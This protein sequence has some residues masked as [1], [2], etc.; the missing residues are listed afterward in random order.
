MKIWSKVGSRILRVF[1]SPNETL[2][3]SPYAINIIKF[4]FAIR[5]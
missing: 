2:Q 5:Y 3:L 1:I 4:N